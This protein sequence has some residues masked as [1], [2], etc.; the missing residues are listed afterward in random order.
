METNTERRPEY[1]RWKH[2]DKYVDLG[3]Y[4]IWREMC[5][6]SGSGGMERR[7]EGKA[8]SFIGE[9]DQWVSGVEKEKSH[10]SRCG[11][12]REKQGYWKKSHDQ[13]HLGRPLPGQIHRQRLSPSMNTFKEGIGPLECACMENMKEP[14]EICARETVEQEKTSRSQRSCPMTSSDP[15]TWKPA[16]LRAGSDG[17]KDHM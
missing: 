11:T 6:G 1:C 4:I 3:C 10:T 13:G 12:Q 14:K 5:R 2:P 9:Q 17:S 15:F 8:V 7:R 16:T